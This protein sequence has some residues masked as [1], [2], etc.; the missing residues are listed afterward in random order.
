MRKLFFGK[1][2]KN[3]QNVNAFQP[4][5]AFRCLYSPFFMPKNLP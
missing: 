1:R 2:Q 4:S 3:K 5:A